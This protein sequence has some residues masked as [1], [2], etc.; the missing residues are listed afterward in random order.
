MLDFNLPIKIVNRR[1]GYPSFF[2]KEVLFHNR[3]YALLKLDMEEK[4]LEFAGLHGDIIIVALPDPLNT[5]FDNGYN[6]ISKYFDNHKAENA[7]KIKI[8]SK[9]EYNEIINN[10][11]MNLHEKQRLIIEVLKDLGYPNIGVL[12]RRNQDYTEKNIELIRKYEGIGYIYVSDNFDDYINVTDKFIA[13][14]HNQI[15]P[16]CEHLREIGLYRDAHHESANAIVRINKIGEKIEI[17]ITDAWSQNPL[18]IKEGMS[19][20][21]KDSE[22]PAVGYV[23]NYN[24]FKKLLVSL[25]NTLYNKDDALD[26][27]S[28]W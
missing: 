6:V 24:E 13:R 9:L 16:I 28:E 17:E 18:Y 3:E 25:S 4:D 8:E 14:N 7:R 27:E 20:T 10:K 15:F 21:K 1:D 11:I 22:S 19:L 26:S 12:V 23:Q 5:F 2:V